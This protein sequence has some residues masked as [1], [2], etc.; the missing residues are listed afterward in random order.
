ME[1]HFSQA[2]DGLLNK[3]YVEITK[4]DGTDYEPDSLRVMQ[5][6]IDRYLCHKNYPASIITVSS[7]SRKKRSPQ[8]RNNFAA[9]EKV[10]A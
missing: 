8:K 4:K 3:F 7:Q 2:L 5:A 1:S 9:R 10:N 6:A